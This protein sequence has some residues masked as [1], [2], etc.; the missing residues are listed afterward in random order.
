M[1]DFA[2]AN[3]II[4]FGYGDVEGGGHSILGNEVVEHFRRL[5][6]EDCIDYTNS[7]IFVDLNKFKKQHV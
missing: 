6:G 3:G 1:I 4:R 7:D 2:K 5:Y